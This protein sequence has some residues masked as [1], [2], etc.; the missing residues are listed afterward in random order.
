M[1]THSNMIVWRIPR[2]EE[3]GGIQSMGS[4]KVGH[5]CATNTFI[6]WMNLEDLMLCEKS[7]SQKEQCVT[8]LICDI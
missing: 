8:L 1:E 3:P 4:Q 6:T 5:D 2:T 7:Q